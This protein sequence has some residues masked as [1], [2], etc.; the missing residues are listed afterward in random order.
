MENL[1]LEIEELLRIISNI[2]WPV[3]IPFLILVGIYVSVQVIFNIR[4]LTTERSKLNFK[5]IIPQTS[6]TLGAM[7]GTGTIIG[8]LGAL[9]KLSISGQIYVEAVAI[10]AL[11]GS[12]V[13]IPISYCETLIAKIVNLSPREYIGKFISKNA[14]EMYVLSL[15]FLYVFAIGGVQFTGIDAI[16][17]TA[18]DKVSNIELSPI[19]RYIYIVIPII[20]IVSIVIFNKREKIFIK[21]M[22][23]MI[24]VAIAF[25]FVFF[26]LFTLKTAHYIPTFI[27]RMIVGFKNPTSIL[28]GIPLGLIFG[29]QRV[30]QIAEPGLG[31]LAMAA[32]KSEASPRVAGFISLTLTM[33]LVVVSIIVT[34]YIASYG[35]NE[36]TIS[37][38]T[39]GVY[40]LVSYFETVISV[41]GNFGFMILFIFIVLSGMTTLL[42]GYFLLNNILDNS[43]YKN[44]IIYIILVFMGS[45]LAIFKF[46]MIFNILDLLLLISIGL[47]ISALAMFAEFE[48]SKYKIRDYN[49]KISNNKVS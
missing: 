39:K 28:F 16:M 18:L 36:G 35:M 13:L 44:N 38:S 20:G 34:S 31:T 41:T 6:V 42:G 12:I 32:S 40:K 9:S 22:I 47:N 23:G 2:A 27:E 3:F 1:I 14:G 29:M 43:K 25:Y 45:V 7:V 11:I 37:L 30:I 5:Y 49:F 19:Q 8:F 4:H 46:D 10:W 48:W 26:G 21:S 24:L 17:I 33:T 15:I